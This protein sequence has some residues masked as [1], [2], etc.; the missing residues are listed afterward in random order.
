MGDHQ[1]VVR[2]KSRSIG[3]EQTRTRVGNPFDS[4]ELDAP[5]ALVE[6]VEQGARAA[7]HDFVHAEL[8]DLARALAHPE[9]A[10]APLNLLDERHPVDLLDES[11]LANGETRADL[12]AKTVERFAKLGAQL[13]GHRG[14][15]R[16][17]EIGPVDHPTL[18]RLNRH[19]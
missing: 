9:R 8:V 5:V 12:A 17:V 7:Q 15:A 14:V 1:S 16:G 18:P 4:V 11:P 19:R 2:Q 3:D 10:H 13:V 6:Q